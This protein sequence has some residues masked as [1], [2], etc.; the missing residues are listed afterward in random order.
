MC[1]TVARSDGLNGRC[2]GERMF[3]TENVPALFK[4]GTL[5]LVPSDEGGL[6]RVAEAMLVIEPFPSNL[7]HE[8]GED[9][10]GHL[11]DDEDAIRA[12]LESIDLRVRCGL[13]SV[14]VQ[15][16]EDLEPC[17]LLSPVSIRDV[18]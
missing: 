2:K 12:E 1:A 7:A 16:H 13:Q 17:A 5:K 6:R 15:H 8:L 3:L 9:I 14:T 10:A 4:K 18:S 11:F